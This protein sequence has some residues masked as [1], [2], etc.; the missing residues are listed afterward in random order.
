MTPF[1]TTYGQDPR[2]RFK[3]QPKINI[4]GPTIKRIQLIDAYNF[5]N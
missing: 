1:Y 4:I 3:P 5:A 2:L